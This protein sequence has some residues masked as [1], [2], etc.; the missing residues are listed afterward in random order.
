MQNIAVFVKRIGLFSSV[1]TPESYRF[2]VVEG[3]HV[4]SVFDLA[5]TFELFAFKYN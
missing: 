2:S 5:L 4:N 3:D 1:V